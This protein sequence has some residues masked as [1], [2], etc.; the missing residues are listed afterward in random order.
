MSEMK[1]TGYPALALTIFFFSG[2]AHSQDSED[3]STIIVTATR[4][5]QAVED[6]SASVEVIDREKIESYSGNSVSEILEAATGVDVAERGN[7]TRISLRG[8]NKE[9]TLILVDGLRRTDKASGN[10]ITNIQ[11]EDIERIEIVRG[12]MSALYGSDA[13]G[14]VINIITSKPQDGLH[15]GFDV[16]GGA[17]DDGQ[18]ETGIAGGYLNWGDNR[19]GHRLSFETRSRGDYRTDKSQLDTDKRSEERRNVSYRGQFE[20]NDTDQLRWSAEYA[21]QD[22]EGI[23]LDPKEDPVTMIETEDRYH[24]SLGYEGIMG[25][26]VTDL[27]A[28]HGSADSTSD[29][30]TGV[31]DDTTSTTDE[32][33]A[34]YTFWPVSSHTMT[35]GY[36]FLGEE[37][38]STAINGEESRDVNSLFLQDQ[39]DIV[40]KVKLTAGARYDEY[41]DFGSA[42]SPNISLAWRPGPWTLRGGYGE[43]FR[44]PSM[45]ELYAD[46]TLA[47]KRRVGN[48]GL[49]AETSRTLEMALA[50]RFKKG[51]VEVVV[52]RTKAEDLIEKYFIQTNPTIE[53]YRNIDEAEID[54][55]EFTWQY[56]PGGTWRLNGSVEYLDAK[57]E[58]TDEPLTHRADLAIKL[59][60][61]VRI[62][63]ATY[64]LR[65][66][67]T[68][69]Y[70][71]FDGI[72]MA[73]TPYYSDFTSFDFRL[74]YQI[75]KP[76][77]LFLGINN[78]F[79]KEVPENMEAGGSPYDP[80]SRYL[81]T[82]YRARF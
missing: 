7:E 17:T 61:S 38:D 55:V 72:T 69:D 80:G 2:I 37:F 40:P 9:H 20:L 14:G 24:L 54:G 12:P 67:H 43:A 62:E 39:W 49:D 26:G 47:R 44:A 27:S 32:L 25:G 30:G 82:G 68:Q 58:K 70:F 19:Q 33:Q 15:Y 5:E 22:D 63:K 29:K 75:A 18:R 50:R 16:T 77:S 13:M 41:S 60:A 21:E 64:R 42:T 4:T 28:G 51:Q 78:L 76:H 81:Y 53:S 11:V 23:G 71:G 65:M 45:M 66:N 36:G 8:M 57:D 73:E 34:Q 46:Y 6:V 10:V 74:D 35:L 56:R 31:Q 79:D 3:L 52:F 48:S 1:T 59:D